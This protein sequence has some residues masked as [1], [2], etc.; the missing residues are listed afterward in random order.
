MIHSVHKHT[1]MIVIGRTYDRAT[2]TVVERV[3]LVAAES[4]GSV[5]G[6]LLRRAD[7]GAGRTRRDGVRR[8]AAVVGKGLS[9]ERCFSQILR[10]P[11][12]R[13]RRGGR[14]WR[15]WRGILGLRA[16]VQLC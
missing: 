3:L 6:R 10:T 14:Q 1:L 2:L 16:I 4:N 13:V 9:Q 5:L 12:R 15:R 7:A 8:A 11:V